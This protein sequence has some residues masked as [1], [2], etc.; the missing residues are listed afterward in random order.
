MGEGARVVDVGCG[1]I[2]AL[3]QL[4][5]IVGPQ[6]TVV[7]VESSAGAIETARG[8]V[9]RSG[10]ANVGLV[11][12]DVNALAPPAIADDRPFDAAYMRF[13]LIH[14]VDP[15]ATLRRVCSAGAIR[16]P[17]PGPRLR[18]RRPF[19]AVRSAGAGQRAGF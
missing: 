10:H 16:R 4:A 14:Q 3:L 8:I 17:R 12:G 15:S 19:P 2:G 18:R 11:H 9:A 13:V 6:G 1:L 5:E 7:G